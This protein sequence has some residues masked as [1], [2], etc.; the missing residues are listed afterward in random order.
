MET[1]VEIRMASLADAEEILKIY[2]PYVTDTAI[3]FEYGVPSL[4]EFAGRIGR[5]LE[6]YPYLAAVEDGRIAGYAYAS[7][8]KERAAYGRAVETTVY[9]RQDCRG[10]GIGK[11]IYTALEEVLRKQN[12]LNLNACIGYTDTPDGHLTNASERF[13]GRMGYK[14]VGHFTKCG[15]KFGRWYD[16]IWMEKL[17]GEHKKNPEPVI[18][19]TKLGDLSGILK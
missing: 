4:E 16:M 9:L 8:F 7:P 5:T 10:R 14:L 13:H 2:T 3:S 19:V 11:I 18:S 15:Y 12:I 1:A 17:I 6:K